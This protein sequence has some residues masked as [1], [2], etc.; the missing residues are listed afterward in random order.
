MA[1]AGSYI[2]ITS[3]LI[4]IQLA[5]NLNSCLAATP[6]HPSGR[7]YN[8][9]I[10]TSCRTTLSP[11][12]CFTTFS[13]YA[14]RIRGSPRL[15]AT[16]ALSVTFKTTRSTSKTLINLSK[17]HGLKRREVAAL[18]DCVEQLGDSVDELKDSISEI[19]Q[20]GSKDFRRRMSDIQ[21]WVSAALTN[22]DTCMDGVS[23]KSM[24]R[25][26]KIK[27]RRRVV[28][29][30]RF[31]SIALAFVNRYASAATHK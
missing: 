24:N 6:I 13:R 25:N 20:P 26:F 10:R 22:E 15:L 17:R 2:S 8:R 30:A 31:T 28:K 29:V 5:I 19:S 7:N 23:W 3:L 21:T 11:N 9:F 1:A 4:L 14:T 16:T 27:V 12:L 18:R